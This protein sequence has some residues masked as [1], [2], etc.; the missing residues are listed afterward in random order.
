MQMLGIMESRADRIASVYGNELEDA[1]GRDPGAVSGMEDSLSLVD[2]L[3]GGGSKHI[4]W[5]VE[6]YLAGNFRMDELTSIANLLKEFDR[7][8]NLMPE[9]D[10]HLSKYDVES[11][12]DMLGAY[13][14]AGKD[15]SRVKSSKRRDE[16]ADLY[17]NGEIEKFYS[18]SDMTIYIPHT[19]RANCFL[20]RG[21]DWCTEDGVDSV[22]NAHKEDL[23]VI[24]L[25]DNT[26]YQIYKN[27]EYD[28]VE[29]RGADGE[30]R[31]ISELLDAHPK[32]RE[33]FKDDIE[34][35]S[36]HEFKDAKDYYEYASGLSEGDSLRF[37]KEDVDREHVE[38]YIVS[39]NGINYVLARL[40][41]GKLSSNNRFIV[42][43]SRARFHHE[44]LLVMPAETYHMTF[45]ALALLI[46]DYD[47]KRVL[48]STMER[49]L[50]SGTNRDIPVALLFHTINTGYLRFTTYKILHDGD[51][52]YEHVITQVIFKFGSALDEFYR[53]RSNL[54][55]THDNDKE[56][57]KELKRLWGEIPKNLKNDMSQREYDSIIAKFEGSEKSSE[58][59]E[60]SLSK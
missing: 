42:D 27:S 59:D 8:S 16:R 4:Q 9:G 33:I 38:N 54:R 39:D 26:K 46:E 49:I 40:D 12:G 43:K 28:T 3:K 31:R 57:I 52:A 53:A 48:E 13:K 41:S 21:T 2:Y 32:L 34:I 25:S 7:A 1:Y 19:A 10:R 14:D 22:Y 60:S 56:Q 20:G 30:T 5:I 55:G 23:Y 24:R 36:A 29:M 45:N 37:G 50:K 6:Q 11:L 44:L 47:G 58:D 18:D 15:V 35:G 51:Y 17:S